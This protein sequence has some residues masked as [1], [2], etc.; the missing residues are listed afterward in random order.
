MPVAKNFKYWIYSK[1]NDIMNRKKFNSND[2]SRRY[3]KAG[4]PTRGTTD[5]VVRGPGGLEPQR[6]TV[7]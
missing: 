1:N 5:I 2:C 6:A 3:L 4:P 7:A